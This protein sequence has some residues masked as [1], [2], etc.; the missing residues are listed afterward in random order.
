M[1][2]NIQY[3]N[4]LSS[5]RKD[6]EDEEQ[7]L[8]FDVK[9]P[10][11]S[12]YSSEEDTVK[13]KNNLQKLGYYETPSYG[14]TPYADDPMFEG[15]KK[16]QKD[17][18]LTVDGRITP[19][20]ETAAKISE[21][22]SKPSN[23][24]ANSLNASIQPSRIGNDAD[25]IKVAKS[26]IIKDSIIKGAIKQ[27]VNPVTKTI[28]DSYKYQDAL[29]N[30]SSLTDKYKHA[31]I[32]CKGAQNGPVGAAIIGTM[33]AAKEAK[34]MVTFRNSPKESWEDWEADVYGIKQG[35][36]NRYGDCDE[37]VQKK[38]KKHY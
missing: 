29:N 10:V 11:S 14:M 4:P 24:S 35:M 13:V 37:L 27:T 16:L 20:G 9:E 18:G 21:K 30:D 7:N 23:S 1:S 32:S 6:E 38:Y 28:R 17:H 8:L 36:L 25:K 5:R 26:N 33:G 34:D 2:N 22:L 12:S 3:I 19:G 31:Y 15:I